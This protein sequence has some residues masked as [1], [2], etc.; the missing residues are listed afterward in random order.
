MGRKLAARGAFALE[1]MT[2]PQ[3]YDCVS[4]KLVARPFMKSDAWLCWSFQAALERWG[5]RAQEPS[6]EAMIDLTLAS[7][8]F[9]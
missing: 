8:D 4:L 7:E 2:H 6:V 3:H 9:R 5:V 1:S